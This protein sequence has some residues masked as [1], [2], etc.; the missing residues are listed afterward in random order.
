MKL[1]YSDKKTG[2]TAQRE[3]GKDSE[4]MLMGK[5]IGEIIEGGPFGLEG[6]RFQ[7]T[8]LSDKMGSP[9]RKEVEGSRKVYILLSK[10]PG[11]IGAKKGKRER[12]LVRGNTI[13]VDTEQVS[14]VITERGSKGEEEL[15]P[16]KA[17][18]KEGEEVPK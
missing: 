11:I 13:S 14:A 17:E 12:K 4:A 5:K 10:G 16:K 2:K 8:G 18:K 3:I 6:C 1:V 15:F 7:I 9:S